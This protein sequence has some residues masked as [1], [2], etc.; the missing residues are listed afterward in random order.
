MVL[1]VLNKQASTTDKKETPTPG[2]SIFA[3]AV[4]KKKADVY[5]RMGFEETED[6]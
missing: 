6:I 3:S 5:T 2:V 4:K 1:K